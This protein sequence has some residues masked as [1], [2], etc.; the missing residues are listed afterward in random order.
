[1][2]TVVITL[3]LEAPRMKVWFIIVT[4]WPDIHCHLHQEFDLIQI[5]KNA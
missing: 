5:G 2:F 1:M 3:S 4:Y